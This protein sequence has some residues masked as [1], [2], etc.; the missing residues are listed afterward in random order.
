MDPTIVFDSQNAA[1]FL[2]GQRNGNDAL[3]GV[4][5]DEVREIVPATAGFKN[6]LEAIISLLNVFV[7]NRP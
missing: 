1:Q 5:Y 2:V 4:L 7:R 6:L 3:P